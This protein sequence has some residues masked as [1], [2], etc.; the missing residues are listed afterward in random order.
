MVASVPLGA[1]LSQNLGSTSLPSHSVTTGTQPESGAAAPRLLSPFDIART[2]NDAAMAYLRTLDD[3][4]ALGRVEAARAAIVRFKAT[5]RNTERPE[6]PCVAWSS[7]VLVNG[8]RHV[9][10]AGHAL[11]VVMSKPDPTF[12][13]SMSDGFQRGGGILPVR[14]G[15]DGAPDGDWGVVELEGGPPEGCPSLPMRSAAAGSTV[16]L[17]GYSGGLGVDGEGRI[18]PADQL[19]EMPVYPLALVGKVR[20]NLATVEI[21]AGT[22]TNYG[23]SGGAIVDLEGNLVGIM[24]AGLRSYWVD[25][26][27][28][29]VPRPLIPEIDSLAG[30]DLTVRLFLSYT[31]VGVF[32][33][34]LHRR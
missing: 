7:G 25:A 22:E 20:T 15:V 11:D 8:G 24:V 2:G 10:V 12:L 4:R 32:Q 3:G 23:A 16:V 6:L 14:G 1:C 31:P 19:M 26:R 5:A 28:G 17:L 34:F 13:V 18:R 9:L 33:E 30:K 21:V 29:S 27:D